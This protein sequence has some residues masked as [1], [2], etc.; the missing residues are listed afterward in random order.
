MSK[1][2][3]K[4][5]KQFEIDSLENACLV[6]RGLL[7]PVI[8]DLEKFK[9]YSTE[10][11]QLL[12]KYKNAGAVPGY[13]YDSIHDKVLYQQRELL[14]FIADHQA[15]SFSYISVRQLLVKKGFLKRSL[16]EKESQI[17]NELLELRNFTFHN[18]QSL[19]VAD[20]E[21]ATKS[22]PDEL[23]GAFIKPMLNPVVIRKVDS[24]SIDMLEDFVQH[25]AIRAEQFETVLSEMK[26][27]Y[28]EMVENLPDNDYIITGMGLGREVQY[29]EQTVTGLNPKTA[30]SKIA[31]L[32]MGIQ[33]GKYDGSD[34]TY[35]KFTRQ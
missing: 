15:S 30:G 21:I 18:A 26:K 2:S 33:K 11:V 34:E 13:D 10:A 31:S 23:K 35:E 3:K 29:I 16:E 4:K 32:S 14:R 25:N 19:T 22:I 27:D 8:T 9:A 20:L 5:Y 17:L 7:V 12:G 24:Y 1:G 28:Q 6:L